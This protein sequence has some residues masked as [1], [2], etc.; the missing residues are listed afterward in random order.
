MLQLAI[1]TFANK[2]KVFFFC[3]KAQ[4]YLALSE[5]IVVQYLCLDSY[6]WIFIGTAALFAVLYV[7]VL[8]AMVI[9]VYWNIR[10]RRENLSQMSE[11]ARSTFEVRKTI[12]LHVNFLFLKCKYSL[13]TI[14]GY[15]FPSEI[16]PRPDDGSCHGNS[17]DCGTPFGAAASPL[18]TGQGPLF[19][20][21]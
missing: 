15:V 3:K 9:G 13:N 21:Q 16:L 11:N 8:V 7:V 14:I 20:L 19:L 1:A 12:T 18:A 6:Q 17:R 4:A 10:K 2:I 5:I